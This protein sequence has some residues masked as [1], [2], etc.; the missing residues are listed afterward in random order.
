M[1]IINYDGGTMKVY[2][3]R[4]SFARTIRY[5]LKNWNK[6][7]IYTHYLWHTTDLTLKGLYEDYNKTYGIEEQWHL[8]HIS[9]KPKGPSPI[10]FD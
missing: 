7:P 10:A 2:N 5:I 3:K 4:E 6:V 1:K 8:V 9:K